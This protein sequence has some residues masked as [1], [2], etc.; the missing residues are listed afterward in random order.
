MARSVETLVV[1]RVIG[2]VIDMFVPS[3]EMTVQYGPRQIGNGCELK[4]SATTMAPK[5]Q[6]NGDR[7]SFY[8]LVMTDPDAPSPSEPTMREWLHWIVADIPG[9]SD[10]TQGKQIVP[11]MGPKP[12]IGIHRYIFVLFKQ[13][14]RMQMFPPHAR[15]NF[16]TRNF[17]EQYGLG[18]PH[19]A[20]YFNAQKEPGP[21]RR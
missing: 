6:L 12:P 4:P 11:Y 16:S 2:D 15:N 9:S 19:G 5:V 13:P 8:T 1:G 20:V 14:G 3:V 10:A 21:R 17:A 7:N 18:T